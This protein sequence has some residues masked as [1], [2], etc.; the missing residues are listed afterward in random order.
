MT[1]DTNLS[2]TIEVK[3]FTFYSLEVNF[4]IDST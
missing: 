3:S 4:K 1:V 2:F